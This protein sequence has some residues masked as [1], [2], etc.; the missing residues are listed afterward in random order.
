TAAAKAA[1][2]R[3]GM[4]ATQAL[5]RCPRLTFFQKDVKAEASAQADLLAH[6][7]GFT[8]D[9]ENTAPG[10]V[11]LALPHVTRLAGDNEPYFSGVGRGVP[12]APFQWARLAEDSQPGLAH[13]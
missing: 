5:A 11:T 8:P 10:V 12:T 2:V 6:A 4:T 1:G 9:Y 13:S 7:A 3:A